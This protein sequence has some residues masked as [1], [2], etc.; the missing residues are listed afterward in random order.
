[1]CKSK[2]AQIITPL[3]LKILNDSLDLN[4][5]LYEQTKCPYILLEIS[6][7]QLLISFF[8]LRKFCIQ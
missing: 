8:T 3:V 6:Q 5:I 4:L 7:T 1:M 2:N